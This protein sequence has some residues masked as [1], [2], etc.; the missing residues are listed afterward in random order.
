MGELHPLR[1]LVRELRRVETGDGLPE[2]LFSATTSMEA[3]M[4]S[5]RGEGVW[6]CST[7][8]GRA[9]LASISSGG[10][11]VRAMVGP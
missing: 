6:A 10:R 7:A 4:S 1:S 9:A 5:C 3:R 8:C 11:V 2:P